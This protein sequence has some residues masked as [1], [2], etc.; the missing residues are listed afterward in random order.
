MRELFVYYRVR[1]SDA[2]ATLAATQQLQA[3]LRN[4]YPGLR[5]RLLRRPDTDT[6]TDTGHDHDHELQTWM[7]TYATEPPQAGVSAEIQA[8]IEA[9][10][11]VLASLIHGERHTEVFIACAS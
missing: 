2:A 9:E 4:R 3:R 6:D 8:A 7:E 11:R 10:A 1:P 5:T